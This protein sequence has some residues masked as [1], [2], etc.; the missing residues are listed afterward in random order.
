MSSETVNIGGTSFRIEP[1]RGHENW[2]LW[3][4]HMTAI[5]CELEL[6]VIIADN[7]KAL[8]PT[9]PSAP[10]ETEQKAIKEWE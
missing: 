10:T 9:I 7:A 1:L 4:W 6:D 5:F 2:M 3:K 8:V